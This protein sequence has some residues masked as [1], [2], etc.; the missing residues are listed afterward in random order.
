VERPGRKRALP[1]FGETDKAEGE[2]KFNKFNKN[3]DRALYKTE[4]GDMLGL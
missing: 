3:H 2:K 4:I 1:P